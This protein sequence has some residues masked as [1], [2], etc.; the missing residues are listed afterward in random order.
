MAVDPN[1]ADLF[2]ARPKTDRS[3]AALLSD[4]AS[5]TVLLVRQELALFKA[6]LQEKFG[7]IGQGATVLGIGVFIALS[8]WGVLMAAAVL[9]LAADG[10][11]LRNATTVGKTFP[12]FSRRWTQMLASP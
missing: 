9:G 12:E 10:L 11:R 4:L 1:G 3:I 5:E 6:E 2:E 7:R 8:G